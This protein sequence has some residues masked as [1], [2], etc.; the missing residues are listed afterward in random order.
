MPPL[1][2]FALAFLL[3]IALT[4]LA[5]VAWPPELLFLA[6]IVSFS[7]L[8]FWR[9]RRGL[10]LC[11]CGVFV[12]LGALRYELA[13]ASP[14]DALTHYHDSGPV[15]LQGVVAQPPDVRDSGTDLRIAVSQIRQGTAQCEPLCEWTAIEGT[16]LARL[17]RYTPYVYGDEVEM[18]G[19]L[20]APPSLPGFSYRDYLAERDIFSQI[21]RPRTR[22][23]AGGQGDPLFGALFALRDSAH[24]VI[25]GSLPEPGASLLSGI[26]LGLYRGIPPETVAAFQRTSTSHILAISG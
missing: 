12:V 13:V 7:A 10:L 2:Y 1:V 26:L 21:D 20:R 15:T 19:T 24:E 25:N 14:H 6:A 8:L 17:P 11:L 9:D 3:G 5:K 22:L 16:L 4:G 18:A 23:L